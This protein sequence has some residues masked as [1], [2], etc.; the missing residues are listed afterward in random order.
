[1]QS[2]FPKLSDTPGKVR[3]TG[4]D[5][6]EHNED[7]YKGVLGMDDKTYKEYQERGII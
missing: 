7:V 4:P 3:W 1:M 5:L 6:G 2:T